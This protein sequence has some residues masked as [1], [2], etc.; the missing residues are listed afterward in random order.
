MLYTMDVLNVYLLP[1]FFDA[2]CRSGYTRSFVWL[3]SKQSQIISQWDKLTVT[4]TNYPFP[5]FLYT[6]F[7]AE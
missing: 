1:F 2:V 4:F 6:S 5:V 7:D 3:I